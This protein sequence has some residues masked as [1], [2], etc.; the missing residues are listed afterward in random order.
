MERSDG[1]TEQ[2]PFPNI[3]EQHNTV[4]RAGFQL[5]RWGTSIHK[6][7]YTEKRWAIGQQLIAPFTGL[8]SGKDRQFHREEKGNLIKSVKEE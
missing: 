5:K 3:Q 8:I 1:R 7:I 6:Y 4:G 2:R